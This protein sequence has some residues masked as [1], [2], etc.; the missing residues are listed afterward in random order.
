MKMDVQDTKFADAWNGFNG[1][2]W[3]KQHARFQTQFVR[4]AVDDTQIPQTALAS[5]E[6]KSRRLDSE[7]MQSMNPRKIQA[8][9]PTILNI[10]HNRFFAD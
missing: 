2:T 1:E 4:P 10:R 3:K 9:Q 7:M 5:K 6:D 8:G